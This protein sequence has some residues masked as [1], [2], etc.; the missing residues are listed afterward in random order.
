MTSTPPWYR[1]LLAMVTSTIPGL[2]HRRHV[3]TSFALL[4]H[5]S[6][7]HTL[8]YLSDHSFSHLSSCKHWSTRGQALDLPSV[9][10]SD[11]TSST[12]WLSKLDFQPRP[13][14]QNTKLYIQQMTNAH[15]DPTASPALPICFLFPFQKRTTPSPQ[16][17]NPRIIFDS[18]LLFPGVLISKTCCRAFNIVTQL[19]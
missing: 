12:E 3:T 9:A 13:L 16:I 7:G 11:L 14:P 18:C 15:P 5:F 6:S 4:T 2:H 10:S 8:P 17:K 1:P 19:K